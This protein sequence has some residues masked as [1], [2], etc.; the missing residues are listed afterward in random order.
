ML[1]QLLTAAFRQVN[2]V[3]T[4]LYM[5]VCV[6]KF[7]LKSSLVFQFKCL[8]TRLMS[9]ISCP[10]Y[11]IQH[12]VA[13]FVLAQTL[14]VWILKTKRCRGHCF[15]ECDTLVCQ[16]NLHPVSLHV[17]SFLERRASGCENDDSPGCTSRGNMIRSRLLQPVLLHECA[18]PQQTCFQ[19]LQSVNAGYSVQPHSRWQKDAPTGAQG[20]SYGLCDRWLL[21]KAIHL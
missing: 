3:S 11:K 7:V 18:Q 4:L 5:Y 21:G 19:C 10:C 14:H 15:D 17:Q 13:W 8:C 16:C 1:L 12:R 2:P 6:I 9:Y 20:C